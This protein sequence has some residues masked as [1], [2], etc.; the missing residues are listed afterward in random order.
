[1]IRRMAYAAAVLTMSVAS[2]AKAKAEW[3]TLG[4]GGGPVVQ[5][6]RG[7]PANAVV[8]DGAVYLFDVG[9][10]TQRALKVAGLDV[11]A[12]RA[13][14]LTHHHLD[15]IGGLLPIVVGRWINQ[16]TMPLQIFGPPGSKTMVD[17]IVTAT[18]PVETAPLLLSDTATR[19]IASTVEAFDIPP[20]DMPTEVFR[21]AAVRITAIAVDHFHRAD[22]T[23]SNAATALAYRIEAGG[24]SFVYSGDTGPSSALVRLA[25]NADVLISEVMDRAAIGRAIDRLA[26]PAAAK[27]GFLRHMDLDHMT[28]A[29][30][31]R[32]AAGAKVKSVVLTHLVPGRD[33]ERSSAGYT[34]RLREFYRGPVTVAFDGQRF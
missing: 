1:M 6:K 20:S 12:V 21:D 25:Q 19:T 33:E 9:E 30:V 22:G 18:G 32:L 10:G 13:V 29:D 31:G 28:P 2:P 24:R 7:Q 5:V 3:V 23:R 26:M 11:G 8:I 27:A 16:A 15:H 34:N 4:T 17:G 14:F